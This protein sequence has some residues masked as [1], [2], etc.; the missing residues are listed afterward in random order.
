MQPGTYK[1][2]RFSIALDQ[3]VRCRLLALSLPEQ[4]KRQL[5]AQWTRARFYTVCCYFAITASCTTL[6]PTW[7]WEHYTSLAWLKHENILLQEVLNNLVQL[8]QPEGS[9]SLGLTVAKR[10]LTESKESLAYW[11]SSCREEPCLILFSSAWCQM[12]T[13]QMWRWGVAKGQYL[14]I[15]HILVHGEYLCFA[16]IDGWVYYLCFLTWILFLDI[17]STSHFFVKMVCNHC[18]LYH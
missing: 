15:A 16:V 6:N 3:G 2:L 12:N 9:C 13:T 7:C 4:G 1:A 5:V 18:T 10:F 14:W 17:K 8:L 11:T